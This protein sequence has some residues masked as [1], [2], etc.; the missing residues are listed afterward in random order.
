MKSI[1]HFPSQT[2][3]L[4]ASAAAI[5]LITGMSASAVAADNGKYRIGIVTFLSGDDGSDVEGD[6]AARERTDVD[7]PR[8][9]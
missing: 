8:P 7:A 4:A 6:A 5:T 1:P 2:F 3:R 9:G